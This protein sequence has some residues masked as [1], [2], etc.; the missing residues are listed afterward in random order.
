MKKFF[1]KSHTRFGLAFLIFALSFLVLIIGI[2]TPE[3]VGFAGDIKGRYM[4]L[5]LLEDSNGDPLII[6]N[7]SLIHIYTDY[8]PG[9]L[10]D[11]VLFESMDLKD[12]YDVIGI[13]WKKS[14]SG[15]ALHYDT[16]KAYSRLAHAINTDFFVQLGMTIVPLTLVVGKDGKILYS[17]RGK[18]NKSALENEIIPIINAK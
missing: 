6:K 4:N 13:E 7:H 18:L 8:C 2:L 16:S 10:K 12:K 17:H 15:K 14:A 11:K 3:R 1:K 9:C 5:K